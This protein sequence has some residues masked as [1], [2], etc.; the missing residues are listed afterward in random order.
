MLHL[1]RLNE[2]KLERDAP[3]VV[4]NQQTLWFDLSRKNLSF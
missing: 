1:R 4:E 3:E 2:G